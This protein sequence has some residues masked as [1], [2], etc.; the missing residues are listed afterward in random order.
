MP[1]V[2]LTPALERE[3]EDAVS[4]GEYSSASEIVRE[5]LRLWR[6]RRARGALYEE[7]LMAQ[8]ELGWD[9][10][11]RGDVEDHDMKSVVDR[12]LAEASR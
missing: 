8:I 1:N 4:S 9:Q 3:I 10:A 11:E 7:W 6:E 2:S 5:G 12:V